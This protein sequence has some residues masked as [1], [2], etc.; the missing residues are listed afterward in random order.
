MVL[1]R[2]IA[3]HVVVSCHGD[4][5]LGLDL[6]E[7]IAERR[8]CLSAEP[9]AYPSLYFSECHLP[10]SP[11]FS[12]GQMAA[13]IFW[14]ILAFDIVSEPCLK[15]VQVEGH[16]ELQMRPRLVWLFRAHPS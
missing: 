12:K 2:T 1:G 7:K 5:E 6:A 16:A 11:R 14:M 8:F 4:L 10:L 9:V 13:Q 3:K 15:D